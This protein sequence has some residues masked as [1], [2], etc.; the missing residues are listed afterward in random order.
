VK[1][2]CVGSVYA[3]AG[4]PEQVYLRSTAAYI[5]GDPKKKQLFESEIEKVQLKYRKKPVR[6]LTRE[7]VLEF[8]E[9]EQKARFQA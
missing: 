2:R 3:H 8:Y 9:A 1:I 4:V 6:E 7:Q 5:I